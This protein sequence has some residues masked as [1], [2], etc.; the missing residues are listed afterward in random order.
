MTTKYLHE[1]IGLTLVEIMITLALLG[2]VLA[3]G[4]SFYF[5]G[6]NSFDQGESQS[7]IQRDIRS[8][9]AKITKEIRN[10]DQISNSPNTFSGQKYYSIRLEGNQ[11][12]I[13]MVNS[14]GFITRQSITSP[15]INTL[16]F[17]L[18]PAKVLRFDVVGNNGKMSK[19]Y[20]ISSEVYLNNLKSGT[21]GQIT[22]IYFTKPVE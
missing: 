14:N 1:K 13:D 12:I 21:I 10:A 8:A 16:F 7:N 19:D 17:E 2:I 3:V 9:A 6:K 5:V 15:V 18:K 4:Y 22:S 20:R 11:I